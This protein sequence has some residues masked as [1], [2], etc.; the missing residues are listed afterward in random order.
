MN[1]PSTFSVAPGATDTNASV[2]NPTRNPAP[3]VD[4]PPRARIPGNDNV[5]AVP[6]AALPESRVTAPFNNNPFHCN[7]GELTAVSAEILTVFA[8]PA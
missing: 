3:I 6:E 4:T 7:A 1:C 8:A 2:V 5:N